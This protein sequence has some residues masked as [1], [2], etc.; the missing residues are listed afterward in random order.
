[1]IF[2]V[3]LFIDNWLLNLFPNT[4]QFS[5]LLG[6][7]GLLTVLNQMPGGLAQ[8]YRQ[9]YEKYLIRLAARQP[10]TAPATPR[11]PALATVGGAQLEG[12]GTLPSSTR[13]RPVSSVNG[14]H[15]ETCVLEVANLTV[16]FGR[17]KALDELSV[18]VEAR[19][20]VGL[21]GNNGAG[22]TTAL[23]AITGLVPVSSGAISFAG[24]DITRLPIGARAGL[25]VGRTYQDARLFAG[26]T[27]REIVQMALLPDTPSFVAGLCRSPRYRAAERRDRLAAEEILERLSL[28]Q[29]ADVRSGELS[30]G[31]KRVVDLAIQ[32]AVR[33][34]LMLLDEPTA[35]LSQNEVKSFGPTLRQVR[36]EIGCA[37]VIIE[38]DMPL[39]LGLADRI[40]C[41]ELGHVIAQ[42][43][44]DEVKND[45]AVVASYLGS[46]EALEF[47]RSGSQQ[48]GRALS[49]AVTA[50]EEGA[51]T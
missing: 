25:G 33:P 35:G 27:P 45:P 17:L 50:P 41:L 9:T 20:V 1:M 43:T 28:T 39:V 46:N 18:R 2:G 13:R 22:K 3:P 8:L 38:H 4:E 31:T 15:P 5:L 24:R 26:L 19:E 34:Q 36:E 21:I 29:F 40:Y 42:G 11:T 51:G 49:G 48:P 23:N 10:A 6:G 37:M 14:G 32:L 47:T 7:L 12:V 30:T 44:P 16:T